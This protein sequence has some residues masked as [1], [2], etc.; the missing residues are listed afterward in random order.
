MD[1]NL[2]QRISFAVVAIPV[3]LGIVWLGGWALALLISL[4]ALLGTRE[5]YNLAR[6]RGVEPLW[7]TGSIIAAAVPV[8]V[9]ATLATD[10]DPLWT[11]VGVLFALPLASITVLVLALLR[12]GVEQRPL[13]A[14]AVT[15][16]GVL[17]AALL[18]AF[19]LLIRAGVPERSWQGVALVF[20]P[21][22]I[23]WI[24]DTAAMF[25]GRA[26][27]RNKL[28]PA[29]SPGKT[30]EGGLA[31]LLGGM[32]TAGVFA[33]WVFP[34]LGVQLNPVS[35]L[36]IGFLLSVIGQLGDLVESLF[37]REAGL[38]DSSHLIPGHGGVLDR[39]DSLYFVIPIAALAY[40]ILGVI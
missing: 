9:Q 1:R 24:C 22:T 18:P 16:F 8:F 5:L 33:L 29:I 40:G 38:K 39:F 13:A 23:T 17:Y 35:A 27:G 14:V 6:Q 15:L 12:R 2:V 34:P 7:L 19:L 11:G 21:L 28:A 31:G 3:A 4:V 36:A 32:L 30:R 20:F 10:G 26:W 37:K 25:G